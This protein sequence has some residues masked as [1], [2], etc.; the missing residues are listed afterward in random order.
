MLT[1][2]GAFLDTGNK[3]EVLVGKAA[4]K[5]QRSVHSGH[6]PIPLSFLASCHPF[7]LSFSFCFVS[8]FSSICNL[9]RKLFKI[10]SAC[11]VA[12]VFSASFLPGTGALVLSAL[13][14]LLRIQSQICL[15]IAA[16]L[17]GFLFFLPVSQKTV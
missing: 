13:L 1:I 4:C 5:I 8:H 9:S 17:S 10:K 14:F 6:L 12:G 11:Q 15:D 7:L 3:Q 2:R 16:T